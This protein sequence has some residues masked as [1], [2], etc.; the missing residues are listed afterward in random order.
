MR[1]LVFLWMIVAVLVG[2]GAPRH[3]PTARTLREAPDRFYDREIVIAGQVQALRSRYPERGNS[4]TYLELADGTARVPV[5]YGMT[6]AEVGSG[7][8]VEVRGVYR[9]MLHAG[10]DVYRDAVEA[11]YVRRLRAAGQSPGTPSGPP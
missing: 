5:I 7:D 2:C 11:E 9:A 10:T 3:A 1:A 4:Y 8:L 6:L